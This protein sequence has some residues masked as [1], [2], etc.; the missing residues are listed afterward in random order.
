MQNIFR[1]LLI[2]VGLSMFLISCEK[3]D[4]FVKKQHETLLDLKTVRTTDV[5]KAF[6]STQTSRNA[7]EW[8][9]PFFDYQDSIRINNSDAYIKV[10]PAVTNIPNTYS[11]LFSL[12]I[13]G[14]IKTVVYNMF[15]NNESSIS[16]FYGSVIITELNGEILSAFEVENNLYTKYFHVKGSG[17]DISILE[18]LNRDGN[19]C[20]D[21]NNED[22][23]VLCGD[24]VIVEGDPPEDSIPITIIFV[25][26]FTLGDDGGGLPIQPPSPTE[27]SAPANDT[28]E[29]TCPPGQIKDDNG[30]CVCA[31]DGYVEDDNGNCIKEECPDGYTENE[32]G[33]CVK[34]PCPEIDNLITNQKYKDKLDELKGKTDEVNETGYGFHTSDNFNLMGMANN[35][36]SVSIKHFN[37]N[38]YTGFVHTHTCVTE[39]PNE[40]NI[41]MPSP[42]DIKA[43]KMLVGRAKMNGRNIHDVF[44]TIVNCDGIFDLR[45]TG[46]FDA[47]NGHNYSDSTDDTYEGYF[48]DTD[49]HILAFKKYLEFEVKLDG[50]ELYQYI[51]DETTD[52]YDVNRLDF[53]QDGDDIEPQND[54]N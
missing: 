32:E 20:V 11:R 45:Y 43:L 41:S 19:D 9:I 1:F 21:E 30:N 4:S 28:N 33:T 25:P 26:E 24:E 39:N 15:P 31:G 7:Q 16:P 34:D 17:L 3:D 8:I 35:G 38:F 42:A 37:L 5:Q 14:E 44:V 36:K 10:T 52:D 29:D 2:F 27:P 47:I 13:D 51:E 12:S 49:N 6:G 40:T 48:E 54:C 18:M 53:N 22:L 46:T 23:W 50:L